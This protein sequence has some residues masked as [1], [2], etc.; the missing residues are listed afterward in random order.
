MTY[1]LQPPQER[2]IPVTRG[3]D[4]AFTVKRVDNAGAPVNFPAGT[5]VWMDIDIDRANPTRVQA[6]V[7]NA[8]AAFTL[9]YTVLD[10][11][12]TSTRWRIL[13][14]VGGAETPLLVGRFE[15]RDG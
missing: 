11:V 12:R 5:Q 6:G 8:L 3:A 14:S 1:L 10:Q 4:R 2:T 15:R 13:M 9:N 7:S